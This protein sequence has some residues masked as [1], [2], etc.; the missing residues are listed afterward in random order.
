MALHR[1]QLVNPF[2][3]WLAAPDLIAAN[4][5]VELRHVDHAITRCHGEKEWQR[6][7]GGRPRSGATQ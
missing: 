7:V 5:S 2:L 3:D 4:P 6:I 1:G